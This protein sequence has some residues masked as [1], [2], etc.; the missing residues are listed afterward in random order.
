MTNLSLPARRRLLPAALALFTGLALAA[1]SNVPAE[2]AGAGGT[3]LNLVGFAVPAE[4]NARI[5]QAWEQTPEGAGVTFETSYG[6][7]GDQSRNVLNGQPADYV[8][9]SVESDVT[10]LVDGG[11]VAEDWKSGPNHGIVSNSVVVFAVRPGNPLGITGWDDLVK[12][13]VEIV[14]PNPASSGAA[15]WNILGAWAHIAANG[16]TDEEATAFL[17]K[18]FENTVALPGSGRDATTAFTSGTG[19]VFITYENE[20]IL[21]RQSGE[22][23]D[24]VVPEDTLLIENPGAV[25]KDADPKA[26]QWLDFVLSDQGQE[27][28]GEAGFRPLSGK[29]PTEVKGANDPA[30][31]FPVPA[32]LYTVANDFGSWKEL[33][34]KFFAEQ[35]GIVTGLLASLG[36]S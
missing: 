20:A 35:T 33:S 25:L 1:C 28:F 10:R 36:K 17:T 21:A 12:P 11:L 23:F 26:S 7:S 31:P 13:G 18:I 22:E 19:N 34:D 6:A 24:Y 29:A 15:R 2:S 4:A 9:F 3:V 30:N 32:K 14:T 5:A 16:G 27:I 8:H